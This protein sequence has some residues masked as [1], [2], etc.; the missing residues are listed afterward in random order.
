MSACPSCGS[1]N[2]DDSVFCAKCGTRLAT[3]G[4]TPRPTSVNSFDIA[5]GV[6]LGLVM[7]SV[8]A[9]LVWGAIF[10]IAQL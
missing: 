8:F 5:F 9:S 3:G 6:F 1:E 4:E 2:P 7:F 10:V